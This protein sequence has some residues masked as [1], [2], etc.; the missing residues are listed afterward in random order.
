MGESLFT[1]LSMENNHHPST[2][3]SMDPSAASAAADDDCDRELMIRQ[4]HQHAHQLSR[5][6]QD[7][8][9]PLSADP[10][11]AAASTPSLALLRP[12][13]VQHARRRPRP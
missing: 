7:I 2:L 5:P 4:P 13:R 10:S 3:L 8:N 9:L 6:P 12:G 1:K 11:A